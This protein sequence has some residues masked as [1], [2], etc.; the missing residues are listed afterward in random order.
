MF[1]KYFNRFFYCSG[2]VE[3]SF[4]KLHFICRIRDTLVLVS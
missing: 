3:F 1:E 4:G 2:L